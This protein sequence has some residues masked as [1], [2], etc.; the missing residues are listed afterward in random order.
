MAYYYIFF[1]F[2]LAS[3]L[4]NLNTTFAVS[5]A[6]DTQTLNTYIVHVELPSSSLSDDLQG[7][8]QTFLPSTPTTSSD[9]PHIMYSYHH[10]FKGFAARLTPDQAKALETKP[11]FISAH[12]Q[13]TLHLH[14][15]HSPTFL[16]LA[17]NTGLW[18][19]SNYGRGVIIGVL[20]TGITPDHPSF[21]DEGVPPPPAR[22]RGVCQLDPPAAC[23]NKLIGAR[24]FNVGNGT[25]LDEDGHGTHTASTAA[26][27]FVAGANVFGN[28]NGTASGI[29]PLAHLA[30]YKVCDSS[31]CPESDILAAM[32][33]A[34]D[35]GVD[36]LSL[37]LG[38]VAHDF[39]TAVAV[40][41]FSA[42]ERG[43]FVS[44]SAGNNGPCLGGVQN[45]APWV[46]SVGSSTTDRRIQAAVVLGNDVE[47][48]GETAFQPADFPATPLPLVYPGANTSNPNALFCTP[49]SLANAQVR[50]R[51]VL[52]ETGGGIAV[53]A[54]G[55]AVRDAGGEAMILVNQ[56]SQGY[57]TDSDSHVLPTA[58]LSYADMLRMQAYL[59][60]TSSPTAAILFRG[61]VFG[62]D[63]APAVAWY[64][65]RGPNL[66]SPNSRTSAK[67]TTPW[68]L[69]PPPRLHGR[70]GSWRTTSWTPPSSPPNRLRRR[71]PPRRTPSS[72]TTR[73][74][75]P[76]SSRRSLGPMTRTTSSASRYRRSRSSRWSSTRA[77]AARLR[78]WGLCR[79]RPT[80]MRLL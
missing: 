53:I 69:S 40:G 6:G 21:R 14:T 72:T 42:V 27:N 58:H 75:R 15:T 71:P 49:E 79:G 55:Q 24:R 62:D 13:E 45:G 74:P 20:D 4:L 50:G 63:R 56:E 51:V 12:P 17:Q 33:A 60:S 44:A 77:P 54:K 61:T 31:G 70:H 9:G 2:T 37:S 41:A 73:R 16:G 28:A 64:S 1:L 10:V 67:P 3:L 11:G 76:S 78:S 65:G 26:G 46:L 19:D 7:W 32:D 68:I 80:A 38:G 43:I 34:I 25:P 57:T 22:W 23:N 30:V 39:L 29:A 18:R 59:N 8:Y 52:C 36:I 47:L 48:D 66:A 5:S 35:D